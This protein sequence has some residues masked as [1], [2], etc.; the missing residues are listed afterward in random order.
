MCQTDKY[1]YDFSFPTYIAVHT[2]FIASLLLNN[3][4]QKFTEQYMLGYHFHFAIFSD[5]IDFLY[6]CNFIWCGSRKHNPVW[7]AV[8]V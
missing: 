2:Y 5:S 4:L 1:E 8:H 7:L 6:S 3:P